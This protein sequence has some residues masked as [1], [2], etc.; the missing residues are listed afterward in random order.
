MEFHFS[1]PCHDVKIDY[2]SRNTMMYDPTAHPDLFGTDPHAENEHDGDRE[3]ANKAPLSEGEW[4]CKL[5][6]NRNK[7][8][9]CSECGSPRPPE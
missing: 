8:K 3:P 2:T 1:M 4:D 7:G 6:G 5:C 9:F